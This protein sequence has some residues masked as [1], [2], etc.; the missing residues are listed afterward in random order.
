MRVRTLTVAWFL[1]LLGPA[2]ALAGNPC[3]REARQQVLECT[4][5]C[6]EDLQIARDGCLNR[7]HECVEV[8]RA[9]RGVC[10]EATGLEAALEQCSAVVRAAKETC[11]AQNSAGSIGLDQC[12]DQ[13]Q[14]VGFQCR[15][16]AREAARPAL[17][18]CG[19]AFGGCARACPPADPATEVVN[20][21]QCRRDAKAAYKTCKASCRETLQFQKDVCRNR[22]HDCVEACRAARDTCREPVETDL[23]TRITQCRTA[24]DA[25]IQNC[26]ALF[27]DGTAEQDQCID[28]AQVAAFQC[29]D[30][31]TEAVR[32]GF[33]ACDDAFRACAEACP[34]V[35]P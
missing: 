10:V 4:A 8:C 9:D 22:D 6:R 21:R 12:I 18:A 19:E 30:G 27:A 17:D 2:A 31:A 35:I 29:R 1:S 33:V 20:P 5:Q 26:R 34:P 7:D 13:A 15:D 16:A 3:I 25:A 23:E 11:R 28:N 14:V 32:P 24:R